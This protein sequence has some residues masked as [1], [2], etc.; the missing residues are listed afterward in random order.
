MITTLCVFDTGFSD[1]EVLGQALLIFIAGY[2][3]TSSTIAFSLYEL[4]MHTEVQRK[5][6]NEIKSVLAEHGNIITYDA[7]KDMVYLDMVV[8]G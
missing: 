6:R 5:L 8:S 2:D 3:T 4:A 7:L 1:A